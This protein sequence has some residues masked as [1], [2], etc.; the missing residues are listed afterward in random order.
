MRSRV[1]ETALVNIKLDSALSGDTCKSGSQSSLDNFGWTSK[2]A[3]SQ[4]NLDIIRDVLAQ[5]RE[6]RT[7]IQIT[8]GNGLVAKQFKECS[9]FLLRQGFL[10]QADDEYVSTKKGE[11]LLDLLL[12]LKGFFGIDQME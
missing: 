12:K 10:T 6:P 7:Q 5:C 8:R 3:L 4:E 1:F 9:Q 11:V 2:Q